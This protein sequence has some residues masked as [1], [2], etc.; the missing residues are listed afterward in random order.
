MNLPN[1][2]F[3]LVVACF[4]LAFWVVHRQLVRPI[5]A[6]LDEREQRVA[7]G[8][9]AFEKAKAAL[10]QALAARE[11]ELAQVAA[12]AQK[13]RARLR[14]EGHRQRREKLEAARAEG[15]R[16]LAEFQAELERETQWARQQLKVHT[17]QLARELAQRLL[18][19]ALAS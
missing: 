4:W 11:K 17:L 1:V 9:E 19:R 13:E 3:L 6:L 14:E 10:E 12:E 8:R 2:S 16:R 18:G 7:S 5:L 15:Q